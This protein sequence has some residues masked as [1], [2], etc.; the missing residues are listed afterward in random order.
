MADPESIDMNE[1]EPVTNYRELLNQQ[2]YKKDQLLS[3]TAL[4]KATSCSYKLQLKPEQEKNDEI[5]QIKQ[6][7]NNILKDEQ[8]I[9]KHETEKFRAKFEKKM[10]ERN[11]I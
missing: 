7:Y 4:L 2:L 11:D 6:Q 9:M 3:Q 5:L 1:N 8:L 10:N